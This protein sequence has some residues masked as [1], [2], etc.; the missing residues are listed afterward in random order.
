M[1][2]RIGLILLC[3][4]LSIGMLTCSQKA[5]AADP[6]YLKIVNPLTG[7]QWFSYASP[8]KSEGDTFI[9]NITIANVVSMLGWEVML[10]WNSSLLEFVR[11]VYPPDNVFAGQNPITMNATSIAGPI[12][13]AA[14]S[15]PGQPGFSGS[16]VLAQVE[17]GIKGAIGESDL[18]FELIDPEYSDVRTYLIDMNLKN[19]PFTPVIAFYDYNFHGDV[20]SD[21]VIDMKDV[22][23]AVQ[24]FNSF[25]NTPEWNIRLDLDDNGRIDM[26]DIVMVLRDFNK[27]V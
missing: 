3:V 9:I 20:N 24:A 21:G 17:L 13:F 18:S 6:T 25:R 4:M 15:G 2:A 7:S 23:L 26:R 5:N 22:M 10:Q 14:L 11:L 19:I 27:H 12:H 8:N 16:G 1:Q